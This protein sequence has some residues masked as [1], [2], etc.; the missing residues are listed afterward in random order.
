MYGAAVRRAAEAVSPHASQRPAFADQAL[1]DRPVLPITLQFY[2]LPFNG[3]EQ[4]TVLFYKL[5]DHS[6]WHSV[7]D[8]GE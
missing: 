4:R 6:P 8:S 2:E 7:V 3:I 1:A 5:F